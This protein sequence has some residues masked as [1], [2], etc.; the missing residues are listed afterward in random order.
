MAK[1]K[2]K[3]PFTEL[4]PK[5]IE[6]ALTAIINEEAKRYELPWHEVEGRKVAMRWGMR[7]VFNKSL[8][9]LF[10]GESI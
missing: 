5:E 9:A 4:L 7:Y 3:N 8:R 2:E 10:P 1:S 6:E